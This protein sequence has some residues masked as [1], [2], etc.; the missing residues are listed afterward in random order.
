MNLT[1]AQ[2]TMAS[3]DTILSFD[4]SVIHTKVHYREEYP[5]GQKDRAT[6]GNIPRALHRQIAEL[7][8]VQGMQIPMTIA[9]LYD[10]FM[11][12]ESVHHETLLAQR[13]ASGKKARK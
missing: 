11:E 1:K 12:Y 13:K 9:A 8:K 5:V 2:N 7:A 6:F 3:K 10:F 4:D